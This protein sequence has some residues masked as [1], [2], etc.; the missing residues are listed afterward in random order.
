MSYNFENF[1]NAYGAQL[2]KIKTILG[3]LHTYPELLAKLN[4]DFLKPED[5]DNPAR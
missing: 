3:Y 4:F 5:L 2:S 1:L